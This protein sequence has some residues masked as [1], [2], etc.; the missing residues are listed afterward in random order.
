MRMFKIE[1]RANETLSVHKVYDWLAD[2]CFSF[3]K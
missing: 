2:R 3:K 1:S